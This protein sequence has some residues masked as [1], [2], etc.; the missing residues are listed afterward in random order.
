MPQQDHQS[1]PPLLTGA[2]CRSSVGL[3]RACASPPGHPTDPPGGALTEGAAEHPPAPPQIRRALLHAPSTAPLHLQLHTSPAATAPEHPRAPLLAKPQ[4][5]E[6][7]SAFQVKILKSSS[8]VG[9]PDGFLCIL[10]A[11]PAPVPGRARER[12]TELT[13]LLFIGL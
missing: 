6:K 1:Q 9:S 2:Q 8:Q 12:E 7:Y 3:N 5:R 10:K 13:L 11:Q 4:P